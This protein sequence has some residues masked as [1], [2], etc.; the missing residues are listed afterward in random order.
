MYAKYWIKMNRSMTEQKNH[1][2]CVLKIA[3]RWV[4]DG[5][6]V[7]ADL[8]GWNLPQEIEG[9]IPDVMA[10]KKGVA[11]VCEIETENTL[12]EHKSQWEKFQKYSENIKG[13]SFWLFLAK[14]DGTC[15][16]VDV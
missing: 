16:Y 10:V 13:T 7:F 3:E 5:Y 6:I 12:E 15:K 4:D 11:R 14:E 2:N 9:Y 1:D 8:D